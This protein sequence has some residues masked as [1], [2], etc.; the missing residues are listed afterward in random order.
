MIRAEIKKKKHE[1][2][3]FMFITVENA[4]KKIEC[5][6]LNECEIDFHRLNRTSTS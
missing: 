4:M 2:L 6:I 3:G 1:R 5:F